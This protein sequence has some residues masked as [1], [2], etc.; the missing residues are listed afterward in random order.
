MADSKPKQQ[1][2]G[3]RE[4]LMSAALEL[5][6]EDKAGLAGLSL[7]RI[8]QACGLTPPAFYTHFSSVEELGL[9]LVSD[10]GRAL[11]E[12]LK[13][14]RA[15][16]DDTAIIEASVA[17]AFSYI[18][19]HQQ[20][21]IFIARERAGGSPH[22]RQQVR[23]EMAAMVAEMTADFEARKLLPPDWS[24]LRKRAATTAVIALGLGMVPDYVD[25]ERAEPGS[26]E[27]LVEQFRQQVDCLLP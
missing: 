10:A 21:F 15:V 9:A 16:S 7:R 23:D 17:A 24:D 14:V 19:E 5:L 27:V 8:S 13:R 3:N 2:K 25:A 4:K 26:G 22:I 18:L 12:I 20:V 1:R 11:R 6:C